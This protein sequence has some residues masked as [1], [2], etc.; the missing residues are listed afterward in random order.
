MRILADENVPGPVV[1]GLRGAGHD[2]V[3]V[4]EAMPGARD[5]EVLE[6]GRV[7]ARLLV[8]YDK[9][10]G[11]LAVRSGLPP[12]SG[13]VLFRL[14]GPNP[15]VDN[16]RRGDRAAWSLSPPHATVPG[17]PVSARPPSREAFRGRHDSIRL[18]TN[19]S[20]SLSMKYT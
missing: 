13:I 20:V 17:W 12:K 10:F 9:D 8:T 6:C 7:D 5:R 16:A 2:V 11:E 4:K 19:R 14:G 1:S 15:D 3:W 18:R